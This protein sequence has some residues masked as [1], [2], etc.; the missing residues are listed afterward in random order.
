[1]ALQSFEFEQDS[2]PSRNADGGWRERVP[3]PDEPSGS[4]SALA[5]HPADRKHRELGSSAA[6]QDGSRIPMAL[7]RPPRT[8]GLVERCGLW[9][10]WFGLTKLLA[11]AAAVVVIVA[12]MWWLLRAPAVPSEQSL[13]RASGSTPAATMPVEERLISAPPTT[14]SSVPATT[15][16][17]TV[18]FVHVAGSV[19]DPGVYRL[20][21]DARVADAVALAGG[22][23]A[24]A[25]SNGLNLAAPLQDGER[26]Y[27]PARGEVEPG[28]VIAPSVASVVADESR[29]DEAGEPPVAP[30]DVNTADQTSL[31]S[32]PGV[33]PATALA[34]IEDRRRNGPFASVDDLERV[35]GIGPAKLASLR[36][37]VVV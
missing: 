8:V 17:S 32:L 25:D 35:P 33:G 29:A 6:P 26:V 27:V 30:V 11:S 13:P 5:G 14:L 19:A 10:D 2:A 20:S 4:T 36:D 12:G 23:T 3:A 28:A 9:L 37:F 21:P 16:V 31:E 15:G 1:M 24:D 7:H 18:L 22:V 34:I